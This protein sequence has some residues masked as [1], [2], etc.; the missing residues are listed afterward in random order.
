MHFLIWIVENCSMDMW[1][2]QSVSMEGFFVFVNSFVCT[3]IMDELCG[4]E[5]MFTEPRSYFACLLF[6]VFYADTFS[7]SL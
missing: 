3:D 5:F 4:S 1:H 7:N 2:L 6:I